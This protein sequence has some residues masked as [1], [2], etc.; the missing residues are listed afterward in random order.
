MTNDPEW[1]DW[2]SI[3]VSYYQKIQFNITLAVKPKS[4]KRAFLLRRSVKNYVRLY[5]VAK[6]ADKELFWTN[7]NV[8]E[9][10]NEFQ[11]P[12]TL[13]ILFLR[14]ENF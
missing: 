3:F 13:Q 10:D 12:T 1:H 6:F 9:S 14:M 5:Y 7:S 4:V 8:L 2:V 11:P